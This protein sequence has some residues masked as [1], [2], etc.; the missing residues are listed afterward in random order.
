[1]HFSERKFLNFHE[2]FTEFYSQGSN[3][4][5][6]SIG[7]SMVQIMA[8]RPPGNKPLSE[9]MMVRLPMHVCVSRPQWVKLGWYPSV[10]VMACCLMALSHYLNLCWLIINEVLGYS[11]V[12]NFTGTAQNI[13]KDLI[14]FFF[15][16][17]F[18]FTS[19]NL[20]PGVII[21]EKC[22]C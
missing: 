16:F 19:S 7:S 8:W 2:S 13:N 21:T 17:V 5:Y 3:W 6:N 10:Q 22:C 9:P 12:G 15:C 1:M 20:L 14:C 18:K 11:P 4:P